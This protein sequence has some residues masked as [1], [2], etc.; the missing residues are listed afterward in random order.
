MCAVVARN[1]FWRKLPSVFYV[2]TVFSGRTR[3]GS[4]FP[5]SLFGLS[6]W[7]SSTQWGR[8]RGFG[9][10]KRGIAVE[11]EASLTSRITECNPKPFTNT[12]HFGGCQMCFS[13]PAK[14]N[15]RLVLCQMVA[16]ECDWA[17]PPCPSNSFPSMCLKV[18]MAR[19]STTQFL[20]LFAVDLKTHVDAFAS[21]K[22]LVYVLLFDWM[23]CNKLWWGLKTGT[24]IWG[25]VI[26]NILIRY[27]RVCSKNKDLKYLNETKGEARAKVKEMAQLLNSVI[28]RRFI[29]SSCDHM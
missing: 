18:Q 28:T 7:S 12:Q 21:H 26:Q 5:K 8:G 13:L 9:M 14:P 24:C 22:P 20:Q 16:S 11:F 6:R 27:M 17:F 3:I 29:Q 4:G 19:T 23:K 1:N 10:G 2:K 25:W 15:L